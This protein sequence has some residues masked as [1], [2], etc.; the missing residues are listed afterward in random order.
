MWKGTG[1]EKARGKWVD[2]VEG[3]VFEK[4]KER[5]RDGGEGD[6]RRRRDGGKGGAGG[7][8]TMGVVGRRAEERQPGRSVEEPGRTGTP[9]PGFLRRLRDEIYAE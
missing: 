8:G 2:G 3:L 4:E 6:G 1:E 9:G 7:A 5:E